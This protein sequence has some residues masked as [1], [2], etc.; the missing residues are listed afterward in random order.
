MPNREG[1]NI[2]SLFCAGKDVSKMGT[3][4]KPMIEGTKNTMSRLSG[5]VLDTSPIYKAIDEL[6]WKVPSPIGSVVKSIYYLIN[7][8]K[9]MGPVFEPN[10][11]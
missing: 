9:L 3:G 8:I 6:I 5:P 4:H 1:Y 7:L 11:G 2:S 10:H